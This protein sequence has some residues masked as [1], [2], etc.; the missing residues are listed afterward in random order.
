MRLL[1]LV[2]FLPVAGCLSGP[3]G[4][5][6]PDP[7][8]LE[9]VEVEDGKADGVPKTFDRNRIFPDELFLADGP[10]AAAVQ[11]FL[12]DTPYGT[13]SWLASRTIGGRPAAEIIVDA[14]RAQGINPALLLVRFQVEGS[15]V[16]RAGDPG[17]LADFALGCGC[18]DAALNCADTFRGLDRQLACSAATLRRWYDASADGTGGWRLG[19][20]RASLDGLKVTPA[21]HATASL[22]AYTP[23]VLP[24]QGGNWLVWNVSRR[25]LAHLAA[26]AAPPADQ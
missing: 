19:R 24:G 15:F 21:T 4:E 8:D 20:T 14:A 9:P 10:D 18:S 11:R 25:Y 2:G 5:L 16:S 23:W 22:Y 7:S 3:Q 26:Q 6:G 12:E 13:R 17:K 1:A